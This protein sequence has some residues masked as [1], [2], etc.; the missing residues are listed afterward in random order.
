MTEEKYLEIKACKEQ[1]EEYKSIIYDFEHG[2]SFSICKAKNTP[3]DI[4]CYHPIYHLKG[5]EKDMLLDYFKNELK[6]FEEKFKE[7]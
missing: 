2:K 7:F 5:S 1:I 4:D 3:Y 6:E